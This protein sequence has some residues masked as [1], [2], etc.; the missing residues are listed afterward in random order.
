M[1]LPNGWPR[2]TLLSGAAALLLLAVP[3][4]ASIMNQFDPATSPPTMVQQARHPT[5]GASLTTAAPASPATLIG[6]APTLTDHDARLAKGPEG[7]FP[8]SAALGANPGGALQFSLPGAGIELLEIPAQPGH[9]GQYAGITYVSREPVEWTPSSDVLVKF[10]QPPA[11]VDSE[12]GPRGF[13]HW[14]NWLDGFSD[15]TADARYSPV[16]LGASGILGIW[17][18]R[19]KRSRT[20]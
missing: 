19:L 12:T 10:R 6:H 18:A 1:R 7:R 9:K 15:A 4:E 5:S 16:V 11:D 20:M 2:R 14:L 8:P 3:A 17:L 13:S